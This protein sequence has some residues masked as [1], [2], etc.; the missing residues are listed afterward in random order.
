MYNNTSMV[1][2][3]FIF[4]LNT[5]IYTYTFTVIYMYI[6][7]TVMSVYRILILR[8]SMMGSSA[9]TV[10]VS[11]GIIGTTY[12]LCPVPRSVFKHNRLTN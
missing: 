8:G 4:N 11:N 6:T 1:M 9:L 7:I 2:I 5:N 3:T 12:F 10:Y